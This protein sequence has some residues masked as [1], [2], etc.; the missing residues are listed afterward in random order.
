MGQ[1]SSIA[2]AQQGFKRSGYALA[3]KV[4]LVVSRGRMVIQPSENVTFCLA[5]LLSGITAG[6]AHGEFSFGKPVGKAPYRLSSR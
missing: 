5:K 6:N 1:S 4:E 2:S 3:Q